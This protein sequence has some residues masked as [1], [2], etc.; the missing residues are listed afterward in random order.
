MGRQGILRQ[1]V[2]FHHTGDPRLQLGLHRVGAL[3]LVLGDIVELAR[4]RHEVVEF[5]G[6]RAVEILLPRQDELV[7]LG[8]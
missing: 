8:A 6:G 7:V 2:A 1:A 5:A 4:V 3:G